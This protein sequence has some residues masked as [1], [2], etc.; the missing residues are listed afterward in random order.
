MP[1]KGRNVKVM[2]PGTA[3]AMVGEATTEDVTT[4]I[5]TI[6][7]TSKQVL[8]PDTAIAV[9]K[10]SG[11]P[12]AAEDGTNTTNIEITGHGIAIGSTCLIINTTR[13]NAKR[14]ATAA[15][16]NN[17]T[18][19]AV[20]SQ[21]QGDSIK[22]CPVES[23]ST[24][25]LNRLRG[26]VTYAGALSREIYIS[27]NY[28]PLAEIGAAKS[29]S[30]KLGASNQ[31]TSIF[32]NTFVVREQA[33]KDVSASIA[34]FYVDD[35]NLDY[36]TGDIPV[37]IEFYIDRTST[38]HIRLWSRMSSEE[39]SSAVDGIIEESIE[40]E[41]TTDNDGNAVAFN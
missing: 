17:L 7:T 22:V 29:I 19:L 36:L 5:Y 33:L 18:V 41:G 15:D 14:L 20:T 23:P 1:T 30:L 9:Y 40:L 21:A 12:S 3:T 28:L 26:T 38:W 25:A 37:M 32:G 6:T 2:I 27:G 13:A 16:A 34:G 39:I 10:Y 4:K 35:S 31:D 8:E 11:S 24:Y